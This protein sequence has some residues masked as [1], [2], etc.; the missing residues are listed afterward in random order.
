MIFPHTRTV[1]YHSSVRCVLKTSSKSF[2]FPSNS[3]FKTKTSS[4]LF[5]SS[6]SLLEQSNHIFSNHPQ[7]YHL[8]NSTLQTQPPLPHHQPKTMTTPKFTIYLT[9][10]TFTRRPSSSA[11]PA[12]ITPDRI[13]FSTTTREL[14]S[15]TYLE[16][17]N[18][19]SA[20]EFEKLLG[21][22]RVDELDIWTETA[23]RMP[24][25]FA[26]DNKTGTERYRIW[27]V[28]KRV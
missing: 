12:S 18:Y 1:R 26:A 3:T 15:H 14:S 11:S 19:F 23:L 21:Q 20:I 2:L 4:L 6:I 27:V 22:T 24:F 8:S 17:A 28:E 7:S 10:T 13:P 9:T 16:D 5:S 25:E